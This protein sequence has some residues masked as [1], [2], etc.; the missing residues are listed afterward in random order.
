MDED[1]NRKNF[2]LNLEISDD[3]IYEA[4]KDI[5]GYLDITPADLKE[6]Y[7]FAYRH[8]LKRITTYVKAHD[9]MTRKVF[10]VKRAAP[11]KE[12]AELMAEKSV[13]G[14]PVIEEDGKV[15]GII[16]EKDFLLHMGAGDKMHFMAVVAECLSGKGCVTMP[17]SSK[18]AEDIM[19]SP[20]ITVR[21]DATVAGISNIFNEKKIN[22]VP[23][24]DSKGRLAGI[25]SRADVMRAPLP[26]D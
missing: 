9:I 11:V 22:R 3:D 7:K 15:A 6:I 13:S 12:V 10:S 4:M 16:S 14:I 5:Q 21:E 25:V 8:A 18:K 23:V 2:P 24:V 26:G 17:I 20:A 19:T 1:I